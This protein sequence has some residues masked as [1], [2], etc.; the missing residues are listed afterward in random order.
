MSPGTVIVGTSIGGVR[1][2]QA[3][4]AGGYTDDIV[5]VGAE[6]RLPYDKPP[7][8]KA[9]LAG[10]AGP[11]AV[12]LLTEQAA[13]DAGIQLVLGR[14]AIRL[15]HLRRGHGTGPGRGQLDGQ[16]QAVESS[17]QRLHRVGVILDADAPPEVPHGIGQGGADHGRL[18]RGG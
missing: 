2:A 5:L 15:D 16:G 14:A 9:M 4:R 11:D 18:D 8:S 1:T 12:C 3:L 17:A 6:P 13:A 10:A 7:L